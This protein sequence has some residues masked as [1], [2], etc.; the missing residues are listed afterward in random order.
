M[1]QC[2]WTTIQAELQKTELVCANCHRIRTQRRTGNHF[3]PDTSLAHVIDYF[4]KDPCT[5]C[6]RTF[7]PEC[8]DFDHRDPATKIESVSSLRNRHHNQLP[9]LLEVIAL[10]DLVCSCCHRLK[11]KREWHQVRQK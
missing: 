4:K 2:S 6:R 11:T 5:I 8:M 7:P 9:R 10:C 1:V 3:Y